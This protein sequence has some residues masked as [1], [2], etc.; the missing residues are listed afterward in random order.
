MYG[1]N[2]YQIMNQTT[3]QVEDDPRQDRKIN[4]IED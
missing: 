1:E 2:Q 4:S 3:T